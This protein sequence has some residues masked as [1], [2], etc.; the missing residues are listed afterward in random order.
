MRPSGG[1][2][3]HAVCVVGLLKDQWREGGRAVSRRGHDEVSHDCMLHYIFLNIT[4]F[5]SLLL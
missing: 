5:L 1:R 4:H 2:G 3:G